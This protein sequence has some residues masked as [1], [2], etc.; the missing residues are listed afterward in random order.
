MSNPTADVFNGSL[1]F[2]P[3]ASQPPSNAS[4]TPMG[5]SRSPTP[6]ATPRRFVRQLTKPLY[7]GR[8]HLAPHGQIESPLAPPWAASS[9][10]RNAPQ[11]CKQASGARGHVRHRLREEDGVISIINVDAMNHHEVATTKVSKGRVH[12]NEQDLKI[13]RKPQCSR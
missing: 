7:Y 3:V 5:G 11:G 4:A 9:G 2:T 8:H 1:G 6:S 13:S 10:P 12:C